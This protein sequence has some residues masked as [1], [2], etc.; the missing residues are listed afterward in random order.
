MGDPRREGRGRLDGIG[1]ECE[2]GEGRALLDGRGVGRG[3][4]GRRER[5]LDESG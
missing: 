5:R 2:K 4:D 1:A 3:L